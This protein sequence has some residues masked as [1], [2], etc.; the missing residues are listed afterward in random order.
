MNIDYKFVNRIVN[1]EKEYDI[2]LY[3]NECGCLSKTCTK[4]NFTFKNLFHF[5]GDISIKLC[6]TLVRL[7]FLED[8]ETSGGT[9]FS[10][11]NLNKS[12]LESL[13]WYE[14]K[15]NIADYY[16]CHEYK[17]RLS[18]ALLDQKVRFFIKDRPGIFIYIPIQKSLDMVMNT[19]YLNN[20]FVKEIKETLL[21]FVNERKEKKYVNQIKICSSLIKRIS[22]YNTC[23]ETQNTL[24]I[25]D[26]VVQLF[27]MKL[28]NIID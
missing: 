2:Q 16:E 9:Y 23:Y 27:N 28:K 3:S 5:F 12:V 4:R 25:N 19:E 1:R 13:F 24:V 7:W 21:K 14:Y 22:E 11:R 6:N 10:I 26:L 15:F 17:K 8:L 20:D 18:N